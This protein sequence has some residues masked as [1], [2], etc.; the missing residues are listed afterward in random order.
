MSVNEIFKQVS[1]VIGDDFMD[2]K[3]R[4]LT[5]FWVQHARQGKIGKACSECGSLLRRRVA[6]DKSECAQCKK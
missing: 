1:I 3:R 5:Y 2:A 4:D 6:H